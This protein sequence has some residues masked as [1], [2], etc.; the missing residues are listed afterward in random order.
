M[1]E[2]FATVQDV[3]D[4]WRP[5]SDAEVIV[6]ETLLDDASDLIRSRWS[7]VDARVTSGS[8][9]TTAVRRVVVGMV[10]RAMTAGD[11]AGVESQSQ[12][13]GPFA[14]S[15]KF[16]NPNGNLYLTA[17]D[18]RLFDDYA[19]RSQVGWLL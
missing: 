8:L 14:F 12:T 16:A 4:R 11:V 9:T 19:K 6:T 1:P 15:T 10:K 17:D 2:P 5:L 13:A 3:E 7:D 18:V